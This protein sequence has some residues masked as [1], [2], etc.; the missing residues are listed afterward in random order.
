M[1]LVWLS[2]TGARKKVCTTGVGAKWKL[3]QQDEELN[4]L[5]QG[6][7]GSLSSSCT[8]CTNFH[9]AYTPVVRT[10]FHGT[11]AL[12]HTYCKF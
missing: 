5:A 11:V 12:N 1:Q 2:A 9:L 6:A 4:S 7:S 10:F 8:C 3:V